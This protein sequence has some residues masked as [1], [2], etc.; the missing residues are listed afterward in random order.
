MGRGGG[1]FW[2]GGQGVCAAAAELW[3]NRYSTFSQGIVMARP[4]TEG[5]NYWISR[6]ETITRW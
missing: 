1:G 4:S 3:V 6:N 5:I 2:W